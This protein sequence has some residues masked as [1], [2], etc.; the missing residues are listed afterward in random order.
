MNNPFKSLGLI[1]SSILVVPV[2]V[3]MFFYAGVKIEKNSKEVE[4]VKRSDY[5]NHET[6]DKN[7]PQITIYNHK[8]GKNQK[9]NLEEYLYG[10]LSGE[11]PS[12]FDME[13]L[14][15]QAVAART[16]VLYKEKNEVSNKHKDAVVCTDF[17][18][19]QEFKSEK[20]LEELKGEKWMKE[21]YPKIKKAVDETK[22]HV[23]MHDDEYILPL[24]FSTSS[25]KTEN[26]EEVF[27]EKTPYLRSVDSPYDDASPKYISST[28]I[29][30]DTFVKTLKRNFEGLNLNQ[31]K[32]SS[33]IKIIERSEGGSIE[34]II[35]GN[36]ELKGRDLRSLFNLNS[37]N[38]N[39]E[40]NKDE[41]IFNV[42]GFGHG[43]GMSQW[44]AD[45]MA[46]EGFFYYEI[47]NHYYT[48][49]TVKD[50]Y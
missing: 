20:E 12:E 23:V 49:T 6:I 21:S 27:S 3:S 41:V 8:L 45:G 39:I 29:K 28:E 22:G 13:A 32:L 19:C 36:Q 37:S 2:V 47:L 26:S 1:S 7:S 50:I 38:F 42:K 34:K 48:D 9:M 40:F 35:V 14:K 43:V 11:M 4:E 17:N 5:I 46:K 18:H 25:G 33:Q 44:G 30:N 15:A 31:K 16:Y 24:Y 10:V